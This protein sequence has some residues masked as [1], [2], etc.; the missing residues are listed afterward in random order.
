MKPSGSVQQWVAITF[1][2]ACVG[3]AIFVPR[4]KFLMAGEGYYVD[5]VGY[6][7]SVE[8]VSV[9]YE[10][11][12]GNSASWEPAI[13]G[14]G[15]FVAFASLATNLTDEDTG[16]LEQVLIR[17]RVNMTTMLVS[18][19]GAGAPGDAD[20]SEPAISEDGRYVAFASEAAN[21]LETA[22]TN[23]VADVFVQDGATGQ[24][25]RVSVASNGIEADD[26]S[27]LPAISADGSI[28][29]FASRATNLV[30]GDT[31]GVADIFV[32]D[33]NAGTTERVSV[34]SSG[35]QGDAES[36]GPAI[37]GDGRFVLFQSAAT[38]LVAGDTN[39]ASDIFLHDRSIGATTLLSRNGAGDSGNDASFDAAISSDGSTAAFASRATDLVAGDT[40]GVADVFVVDLVSGGIS[41]VS[42]DSQGIEADGYSRRPALS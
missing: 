24:I 40:N 8:R 3:L 37:S 13:S 4:A 26:E 9:G 36:I 19:S 2:L 25:I 11:V 12:G 38:N 16:G 31:N 10:N 23:G 34:T 20:S 14:D 1:A 21:L 18:R 15:Q 17:D 5:Y 30:A 22:D 27:G 42:V 33:L 32:H 39:D 41:R 35:V 7:D 29:A 28:V 6:V